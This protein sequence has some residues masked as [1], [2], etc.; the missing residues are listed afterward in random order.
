MSFY[1]IN[2]KEIQISSDI[3]ASSED[4][5]TIATAETVISENIVTEYTDGYMVLARDGK[6]YSN[7]NFCVLN[8]DVVEKQWYEFTTFG[9]I[10]L[11]SAN[12]VAFLDSDGNRVVGLLEYPYYNIEDVDT[13]NFIYRV[14]APENASKILVNVYSS[15]KDDG[16]IKEVTVEKYNLKGLEVTQDNLDEELHGK[17]YLKKTAEIINKP[18]D[19]SGKSIVAFGDSITVGYGLSSF[20][21]SYINQ[22][23]T[24]V[25]ATI[26]NRA[27]SGTW[28]TNDATN[29]IYEKIMAYTGT[30]D[31]IWI[32]GG[33]NDYNQGK[34][35]GE[36]GS[37]D[38]TTFYGALENI[39]THIS[40]TFPD[41]TVIFMT[42]IPYLNVTGKE[43]ASIDEYRNAVFEVATKHGFNVVR[44]DKL[45]FPEKVCELSK[46]MYIDKIHPTEAGHTN[47]MFHGIC[48]KLL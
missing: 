25:G 11:T 35:L 46:V 2:G 37:V 12:C 24:K 6:T 4:L 42:P 43:I 18:F 22:F 40:T 33:T 34:P 41:A 26:D 1:D 19:F 7:A 27:V 21:L 3:Q 5:E 17:L 10:H 39:C 15:K 8:A 14:Y 38:E 16:Y 28:I 44:G 32:A 13:S 45:G 48:G 47:L 23:A 29:S 9:D 36:F 30:P 31:F 20:N